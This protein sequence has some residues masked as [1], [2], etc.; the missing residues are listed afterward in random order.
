MIHLKHFPL[1]RAGSCNLPFSSILNGPFLPIHLPVVSTVFRS[2]SASSGLFFSCPSHIYPIIVQVDPVYTFILHFRSCC[3]SIISI[4]TKASHAYSLLSV[5]LLEHIPSCLLLKNGSSLNKVW[6]YHQQ[7][8]TFFQCL[9][10]HYFALSSSVYHSSC[11]SPQSFLR[12]PYLRHA[13][14]VS[15]SSSAQKLS[16]L[17]PSVMA[18]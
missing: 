11:F 17:T 16:R 15:P 3:T 10:Q 8:S 1:V 14:T 18:L 6:K 5:L 12:R 13:F 2:A 9:L 4:I 7:H